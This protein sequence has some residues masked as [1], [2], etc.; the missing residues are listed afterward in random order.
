M[1]YQRN[2]GA[3]VPRRICQEVHRQL[4]DLFD[5]PDQEQAQE[6]ANRMVSAYQHRFPELANWLEET[7]DEPLNVF[8]LP[9]EHRKRL[10][11]TNELERYHQEVWRRTRVV[12]IFPNSASCLRLTSALAMEQSEDW[13]T[14][15]RYLIMQVLEEELLAIHNNALMAEAT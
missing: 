3:K 2:A 4:R 8:S 15:N 1:H 14:N 5:A 6:R 9:A 11:T 10:R 13:L 12:R 7:I